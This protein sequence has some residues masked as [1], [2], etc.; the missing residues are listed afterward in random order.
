M[1]QNVMK[2][3]VMLRKHKLCVFDIKVF[4]KIFGPKE[5]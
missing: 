2:Q 5:E 4:I 3:I 1:S